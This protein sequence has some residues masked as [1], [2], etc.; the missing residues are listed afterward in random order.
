MPEFSKS[1]EVLE[2]KPRNAFDVESVLPVFGEQSAA[3]IFLLNPSADCLTFEPE[4]LP[5]YGEE[6][7]FNYW[8][9]AR[10]GTRHGGRIY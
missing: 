9:H 5:N 10:P 1:R 3:R 2:A 7:R 4:L 6:S 8:S